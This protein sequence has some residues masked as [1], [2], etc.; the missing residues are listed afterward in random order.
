M[1]N[2]DQQFKVWRALGKMG[3][4]FGF[5]QFH[6]AKTDNAA[7]PPCIRYYDSRTLRI[8]TGLLRVSRYDESNPYEY[9]YNYD[10][11]L[12][13]KITDAFFDSGDEEL[14][15]IAW[16][17][18]DE[19]YCDDR[20]HK[21]DEMFKAR[22][23]SSL[24]YREGEDLYN[25]SPEFKTE[26]LLMKPLDAKNAMSL[27]RYMKKMRDP[28][29]TAKAFGLDGYDHRIEYAPINFSI[30]LHDGTLVGLIGIYQ[31][32]NTLTDPLAYE[33]QFYIKDDC[34]GHGYAAEALKGLI[35]QIDKDQI[36]VLDQP[37]YSGVYEL[38]K[39]DFS[40]LRGA[41]DTNNVA[42]IKTMTKLMSDDGCFRI[43][44]GER[45]KEGSLIKYEKIFS[46]VVGGIDE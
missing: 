28:A 35:D 18:F 16:N 43:C 39:P 25:R 40:I 20:F 33:V 38:M 15:K 10:I 46:Y 30:H 19:C 5:D 17:S 32:K 6:E 36:I 12:I 2:I 3:I 8:L 21:V 45:G 24:R 4:K 31:S 14:R 9:D 1:L 13:N 22:H 41:C 23:E 11:D 34:R 42:S 27:E 26:R 37:N 29:C 7:A 44:Y